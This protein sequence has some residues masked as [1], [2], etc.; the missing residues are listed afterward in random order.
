MTKT[1]WSTER[2]HREGGG[3]GCLV[4]ITS[5]FGSVWRQVISPLLFYVQHIMVV[6]SPSDGGGGIRGK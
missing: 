5:E 4:E 3:R 1:D 2:T 6:V